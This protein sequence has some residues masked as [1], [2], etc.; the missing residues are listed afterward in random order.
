MYEV[1]N[2]LV[3]AQ[4]IILNTIYC[5]SGINRV[6]VWNPL[7]KTIISDGVLP[8][9]QPPAAETVQYNPIVNL[10]FLTTA[11]SRWAFCLN[12]LCTAQTLDYMTTEQ[13]SDG[14]VVDRVQDL[15][16]ALTK[17][18]DR[19][20]FYSRNPDY[21]VYLSIHVC[22]YKQNCNMT[23][24]ALL[25]N[26]NTLGS[27]PPGNISY[28]MEG[29]PDNYVFDFSTGA[30]E[31]LATDLNYDENLAKAPKFTPETNIIPGCTWAF[32]SQF[33]AHIE[34]EDVIHQKL[35]PNDK[36]S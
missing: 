3:E 33:R 20:T 32:S 2:Q 12:H 13:I 30:G 31:I 8:V 22:R 7:F 11:H 19:V 9:A 21:P 16:F 25:S 26:W 35:E 36:Y 1:V 24:Q 6:G 28:N 18:I 15:Y 14:L 10:G 5:Q 34:V 27:V 29:L 23:P 17:S 4:N